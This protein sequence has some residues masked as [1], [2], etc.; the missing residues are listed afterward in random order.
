MDDEKKFLVLE[1]FDG[2]FKINVCFQLKS[3]E[4][5]IEDDRNLKITFRNDVQVKKLK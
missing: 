5:V 2:K 3:I 1:E 4:S